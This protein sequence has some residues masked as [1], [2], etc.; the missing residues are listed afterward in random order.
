MRLRRGILPALAGLLGTVPAL[1]HAQAPSPAQIFKTFQ[2][3]QK[4]VDYDTP[5]GE[6]VAACK[7]EQVKAADGKVIG[8]AVKDGQGKLLRRFIDSALARGV[9]GKSQLDQWSYFKDGFEVYR[10]VDLDR[11]GSLDEC[12]WLNAGG[13]RVA[14]I[15]GG[16]IVGWRR[17]SA[18]E[19]SKVF[20]Q[21]LVSGDGSLLASVMATPEELTALGVPAAEVQKAADA[22][23]RRVKEL[24][25][26]QKGLKNWN[27]QTTWSRFDGILPHVIP[28]DVTGKDDLLLYENAVIFATPAGSGDPL[29]MAYL[30][31]PEMVRVGDAWK[32]VQ[33][34]RPID[35]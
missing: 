33:L 22:A 23:A 18:E 24:E 9:E 4:G 25:A 29:A 10:E 8:W 34:P 20:V 32:F 27:S 31:A 2:P 19:A 35:P 1:A 30:Q 11:D 5:E 28:A 13:T 14:T 7:V 26:L 17:L 6:A 15:K 12:R 16:K 21:A 3:T